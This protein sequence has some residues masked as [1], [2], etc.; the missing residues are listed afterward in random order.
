MSEEAGSLRWIDSQR[1][2]MIQLVQRWSGINSGT[3]NSAGVARFAEEVAAEFA[4]LSPTMERLPVPPAE[5][6]GSD[7]K[8]HHAPLGPLLRMTK[9][10]DS[11]RRIFLCIHLD[12]VYPP[13]SPFQQSKMLDARTLNGPGVVDAKGGLVVMLTALRAFEQS[14]LASQVGWEVMLNPDEEI[15]SP[16]SA[17][18]LVDA[19]K[20]NHFGLLF[21]PAMPDGSIVGQRK[22]SGNFTAAIHGRAAHAGR[23]FDEGRSAILA[24]ADLVSRIEAMQKE[25]PGATIN[26]GKVEGGGALNVVPDL[27]IARF[28]MRTTS[29]DDQTRIE[30]AFSEAI[31]QTKK[32][33]GI[34]IDLH[35]GFH[36]P[37]KPL[38]ARSEKL[39]QLTRECGQQLGLELNVR[40][41]GGTCDGNRLAAAGL[42]VIDT[43]GPVGGNLHSEQEYLLINSLT[44]RASLTLL[45]LSRLAAGEAI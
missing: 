25:I 2:Q 17:T 31:E 28:N 23:D 21:E 35:G 42:P 1:D 30:K 7:G 16:G 6:V 13:E 38:D 5:M 34:S 12:T 11:P 33:D 29:P 10:P 32:R 39:I 43:L 15:G 4:S 18:M 27:A 45:L 40:P 24:M 22:G 14:P 9:R 36:S 8:I 41:S 3:F 37:P 20:R 19:A 44:Q 26:C